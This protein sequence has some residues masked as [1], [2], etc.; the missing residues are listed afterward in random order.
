MNP[1]DLISNHFRLVPDQ[2]SAL[3]RLSLVSI[4]DLLYHFPARYEQAGSAGHASAK[5]VKLDHP[6]MVYSFN[7]AGSAVVDVDGLRLDL[8]FL[9]DKGEK[10]DWFSIVKDGTP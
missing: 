10:R 8:T 1:N 6:A 4:R 3:R 9:N 2:T 5:P 7:E